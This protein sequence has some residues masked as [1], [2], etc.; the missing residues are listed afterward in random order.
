MWDFCLLDAKLPEP[1]RPPEE[2]GEFRLEPSRYM[3][4]WKTD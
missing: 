4:A 1:L 3:Y 2:P